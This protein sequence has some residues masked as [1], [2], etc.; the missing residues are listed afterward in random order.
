M[1]VRMCI[2]YFRVGIMTLYDLYIPTQST[3][4]LPIKMFDVEYVL[5]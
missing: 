5:F 3:S 2:M 1:R 4:T